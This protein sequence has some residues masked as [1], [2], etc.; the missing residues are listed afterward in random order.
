MEKMRHN[1][2][3]SLALVKSELKICV[4]RRTR[5]C[6]SNSSASNVLLDV[7]SLATWLPSEYVGP[8][9]WLRWLFGTNTRYS[10][11]V[12]PFNSPAMSNPSLEAGVTNVSYW[13]ATQWVPFVDLNT[14]KTTGTSLSGSSRCAGE[15]RILACT[16]N[17]LVRW[18]LGA[19]KSE[20]AILSSQ[21]VPIARAWLRDWNSRV[22][23]KRR[24]FAKY[25]SVELTKSGNF[26][27][28][29][30]FCEITLWQERF[31]I[32]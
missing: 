17:Q 25:F 10:A 3:G 18:L 7:V 27:V 8:H 28:R 5:C 30:A 6:L 11:P 1:T 19:S 9:W 22:L 29:N 16:R 4:C 26:G 14:Q 12:W 21:C 24:E 15:D 23:S 31:D 32:M 13:L 2:R 20:T